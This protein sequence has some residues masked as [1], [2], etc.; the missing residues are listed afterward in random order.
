MPAMFSPSRQTGGPYHRKP[1]KR[2]HAALAP[3]LASQQEKS[4]SGWPDASRDLLVRDMAVAVSGKLAID[5]QE[6]RQSL[7][8]SPT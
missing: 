7:W 6:G 5:L 4:S 1:D 2:G 3:V 8:H